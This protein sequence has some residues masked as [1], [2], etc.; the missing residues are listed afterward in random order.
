MAEP[1]DGLSD[2]LRRCIAVESPGETRTAIFF[3]NSVQ[4]DWY[5]QKRLDLETIAKEQQTA[6]VYD[7][8]AH[9][10]HFSLN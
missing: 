5:P 10:V 8:I 1:V 9:I 6:I 2:Y 4:T 3:K 7:E